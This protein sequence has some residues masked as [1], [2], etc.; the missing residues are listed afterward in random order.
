M[1]KGPSTEASS[2]EQEILKAA[3]RLFEL[4]NQEAEAKTLTLKCCGS[5][6][7]RL[8][9]CYEYGFGTERSLYKAVKCYRAAAES[10]FPNGRAKLDHFSKHG[11]CLW[12]TEDGSTDWD[13]I[14]TRL[15]EDDV[16]GTEP[17]EI[18]VAPTMYI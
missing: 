3:A 13:L 7:F 10:G 4:L 1:I 12:A 16:P 15:K 6:L 8:G 9:V 11:F 18:Q 17:T 2:S 14:Y 5:V